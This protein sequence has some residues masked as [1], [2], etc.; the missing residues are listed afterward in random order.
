MEFDKKCFFTNKPQPII[1]LLGV[2]INKIESGKEHVLLLTKEKELYAWGSN[3]QGQIGINKKQSQKTVEYFSTQ[4]VETGGGQTNR[5]VT[6]TGRSF[7]KEDRDEEKDEEGEGEEGEHKE[8]PSGNLSFFA[9]L[10]ENDDEKPG[11]GM[12][13]IVKTCTKNFMGVPT[14]IASL[15]GKV[16]SIH[17]GDYNSYS[18]VHI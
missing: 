12:S 17:C 16:E 3:E 8:Q 10:Q 13:Q 6:E 15:I 14:K 11:G 4:K 2:K 1:S 7:A 18:L 9:K 5:T